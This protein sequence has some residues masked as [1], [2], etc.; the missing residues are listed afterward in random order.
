MG[1]E[2]DDM[3]DAGLTTEDGLAEALGMDIDN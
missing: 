1:D 3:L 2:Y